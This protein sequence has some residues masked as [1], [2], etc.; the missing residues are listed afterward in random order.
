MSVGEVRFGLGL[1]TLIIKESNCKI[2]LEDEETIEYLIIF[3]PCVG[4]KG[5]SAFK[6]ITEN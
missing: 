4:I 3:N 1:V 6:S 2:E 5:F